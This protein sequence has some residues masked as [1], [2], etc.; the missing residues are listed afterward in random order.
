MVQYTYVDEPVEDFEYI[1]TEQKYLEFNEKN[2][3]NR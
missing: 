1:L 2:I 3:K